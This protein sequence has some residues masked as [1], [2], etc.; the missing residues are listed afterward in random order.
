[1]KCRANV[2]ALPLSAVMAL[3]V[4][5]FAVPL[6][7][8]VPAGASSVSKLPKSTIRVPRDEPTIQ[9]AVDAAKPGTLVLVAPGVYNEAVTVGPK[10]HDIVIRGE[11]RAT[12]I[13][14]G[15]FSAE[16]GQDNGFHVRADGVAIENITARNFVNNGFFW[17]GVDGYRGSYLTAIRNGDYGIYAFGSVHGQFDHDYASGSPDAGF[18]IGQCKPCHALITD[19]EAEWNGLG[20]SGT[21]AGGDLVITRSSFHDNRAGIVPNSET[22]EK[23][24]PQRG[25]TIVGNTVFSNNNLKTAAIEIADIATGNGILLA[26]GNDDIVERNLVHTQVV[27]GISVIPLPEKILDPSNPKSKNFSATGNQV[28][29]NSLSDN[30]LDLVLVSTLDDASQSG[31]NCFSGNHAATTLPTGLEQ[32]LPCT[33]TGT[34]TFKADIPKFLQLL[35]SPKPTPPDFK[36]VPLPDPPALANMPGRLT[37][38]ARPARHLPKHVNLKQIPLPTA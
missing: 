13:L 17:E 18:Y 5:A 8:G 19:S 21:N 9:L 14:D 6:V 36:A 35:S 33:G 2:G 7:P 27:T 10:H 30:L 25:A 3:A 37:A 15:R 29:D 22:G 4:L 38:K 16:T 32:V 24:S 12:A 28:R 11:D 31:R 23:L 1:M 34:G 20:Y 26:G